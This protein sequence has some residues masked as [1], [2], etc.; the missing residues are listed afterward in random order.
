MYTFSHTSLNDISDIKKIN[1]LCLPENYPYRL[2][3]DII[4]CFPKY[5]FTC[6]KDNIIVGYLL[7]GNNF[8]DNNLNEI[9]IFSIAVS[10]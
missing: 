10:T 9:V 5:N 4:N 8:I 2:W 3:F 7:G 6:K 1:E